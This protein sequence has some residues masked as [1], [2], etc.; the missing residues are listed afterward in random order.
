MTKNEVGKM[1]IELIDFMTSERKHIAVCD[2]NIIDK[3]IE[4]LRW[5]WQ[6]YKKD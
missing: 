2:A 1:I 5:Y 3:A 6:F 4:I